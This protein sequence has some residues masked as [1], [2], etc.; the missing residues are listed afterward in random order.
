MSTYSPLA[1]PRPSAPMGST[2]APMGY[3]APPEGYQSF[4]SNPSSRP[5]LY[6]R[7]RRALLIIL[8]VRMIVT[9]IFVMNVIPKLQHEAAKMAEE[10]ATLMYSVFWIINVSLACL[11]LFGFVAVYREKLLHDPG[12]RRYVDCRQDSTTVLHLK[13]EYWKRCHLLLFVVGNCHGLLRSWPAVETRS[14][15]YHCICLIRKPLL[16]LGDN[17]E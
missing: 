11:T 7:V 17:S 4:N 10:E 16:V 9:P 6:Q 2:T 1:T 14:S 8:G 15:G 5:Q 13:N 12:F 3:S